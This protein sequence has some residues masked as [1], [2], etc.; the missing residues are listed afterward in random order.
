MLICLFHL[1]SDIS[2]LVEGQ[3]KFNLRK[4]VFGIVKIIKIYFEKIFF[5]L[6][7]IFIDHLT[8]KS[9]LLMHVYNTVTDYEL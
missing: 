5:F 7:N 9:H 4:G 1:W 8:V 6:L 2:R 3:F